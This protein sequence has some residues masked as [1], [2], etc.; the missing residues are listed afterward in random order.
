MLAYLGEATREALSHENRMDRLH[1][2]PRAGKPG[3]SCWLSGM[4]DMGWLHRPD[5]E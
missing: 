5:Q 3:G 2:Q 1:V 4:N